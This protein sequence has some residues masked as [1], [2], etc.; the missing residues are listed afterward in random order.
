[1][2]L[3]NEYDDRRCIRVVLCRYRGIKDMLLSDRRA[4]FA[5]HLSSLRTTITQLEVPIHTRVSLCNRLQYQ[6]STLKSDKVV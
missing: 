3:N 4:A 6:Y 2:T 1:M 5:I